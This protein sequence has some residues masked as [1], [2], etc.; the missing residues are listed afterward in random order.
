M[1][2][3]GF[4]ANTWAR[5]EL[6]AARLLQEWGWPDAR[7]TPPGPDGGLDVVGTNVVAQVKTRAHDIGAP[8]IREFVGAA[9]GLPDAQK[10]FFSASGYTRQ[11]VE[12]ADR[13]DTALFAFEARG[14]GEP[15]NPAARRIIEWTKERV[16]PPP[17]R[18]TP[19][20]PPRKP[21]PSTL[22]DL[23]DV[24]MRAT[25]RRAMSWAERKRA[26]RLG[27]HNIGSA[28]PR[29]T[30]RTETK[31]PPTE[32]MRSARRLGKRKPLLPAEGRRGRGSA[33]R[34]SRPRHRPR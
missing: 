28:K 24:A 32:A 26:A 34:R 25:E 16:E 5:A 19:E 15:V 23:A 17:V 18:S 2:E 9:H 30:K 12:V 7:V 13:T 31:P 33:A 4:R 29:P 27:A 14:A 6:N 20:P 10:V 3:Q 11:A 8:A 21:R 22:G 1:E